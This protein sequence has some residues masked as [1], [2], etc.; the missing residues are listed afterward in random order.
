VPESTW[1][2]RYSRWR[3]VD[4]FDDGEGNLFLEEREPLEPPAEEFYREHTA[5]EG[6]T[7]FSLAGYYYKGLLPRAAAYWWAIAEANDIVDPT[8]PLVPSRK[9]KIP[10]YEYVQKWQAERHEVYV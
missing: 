5:V 4:V 7:P 6:D 8:Q 1:I 3:G 10:D 2:D 9:Y